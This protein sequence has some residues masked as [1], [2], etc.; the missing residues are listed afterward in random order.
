MLKP[1]QKG[2]ISHIKPK[3]HSAIWR[4]QIQPKQQTKW[5]VLKCISRWITMNEVQNTYKEIFIFKRNQCIWS[6][7]K[8]GLGMGK[9]RKGRLSL[10]TT[11]ILHT[12]MNAFHPQTIKHFFLKASTIL[13]LLRIAEAR[14]VKPLAQGHTIQ[15]GIV[16]SLTLLF[17]CL[18]CPIVL[19]GQC[20]DRQQAF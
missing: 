3:P 2:H 16:S 9:L 13:V 5:I 10:S 11:E 15:Y 17:Q 14:H 19:P 20:V 6:P 4:M 1:S 18:P 8:P 7:R 12:H